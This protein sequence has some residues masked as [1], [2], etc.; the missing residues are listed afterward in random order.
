M[1]RFLLPVLKNHDH[2]AFD[3]VAYSLSPM[4]DS[5]TERIR[6]HMDQWRQMESLSDQQAA[7]Q[8]RADEIDILVDLAMHTGGNALALWC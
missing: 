1:A 8:I 5:T 6:P 4:T 7:E 3:I 2:A